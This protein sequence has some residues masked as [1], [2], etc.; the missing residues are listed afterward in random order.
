MARITSRYGPLYAPEA[1]GNL[2]G[3]MSYPPFNH[4]QTEA[5]KD[6]WGQALPRGHAGGQYPRNNSQPHQLRIGIV[7]NL[8]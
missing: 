6:Q 8:S 5:K 3:R 7:S 4:T 2:E 1:V